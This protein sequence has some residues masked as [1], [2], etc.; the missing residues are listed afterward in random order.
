[1]AFTIPDGWRAE[2]ADERKQPYMHALEEFVE[3]E[4]EHHTVFPPARDVFNAL[5]LT[6]FADTRVLLLGQDPYHDDGQAHGLAFS[7]PRGVRF[8]PSLRN[9]FKELVADIGCAMPKSGDLTPWAQ[10]GVLL[11]NTVL[12]VRAHEPAS[13][14]GK[15]WE[16]FTDAMIAVL[17]KRSRPM[18]FLLWGA[19]AQRKR[20]MIDEREHLVLVSAHPSPLSA[21]RGF[22]GSRPFTAVNEALKLQEQQPIHW[23]LDDA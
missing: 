11:L 20:A 12:T 2:L 8:P 22:F 3:R 9:I 16:R 4:R 10:Q 19:H 23:A 17:N 21:R 7:V 1:M 6:P 18:V 5:A 14:A 15:G 13:H